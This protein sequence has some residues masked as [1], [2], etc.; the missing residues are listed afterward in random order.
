M[1][2]NDNKF[3][4]LDSETIIEM[5]RL[6]RVEYTAELIFGLSK[7]VGKVLNFVFIKPIKAFDRHIR[8][9]QELLSLDDRLLKD[10]GVSRWE[11]PM[12][13]K[14]AVNRKPTLRNTSENITSV[15]PLLSLLKAS[16]EEKERHNSDHPMAA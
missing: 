7:V 14:G 2:S 6:E 8:L 12:A 10:I 1:I 13:I 3:T 15:Y 16:A 4:K 5:A 11:I 9:N